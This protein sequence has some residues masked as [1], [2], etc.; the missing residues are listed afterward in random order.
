[1]ITVGGLSAPQAELKQYATQ[2]L[3]GPGIWAYPAYDSYEGS[4]TRA[5]RE[6]DL[7]AISLLNAGQEPLQSFYTLKRLLDPINEGLADPRLKGSFAEAG[8][9]TID[10]IADL[11]GILDDFAPTPEVRLTKLQKVLH[12]LKPELI[13]L[14]D[15]NI[16][17]LYLQLGT[18]PVRQ[19]KGRSYRDFALAWLPAVQDDLCRHMDFWQEITGLAD[20]KLPITP[21]RALDICAWKMGEKRS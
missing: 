19:V 13:P 18:R 16:W 10:A 9:D 6:A 8:Q 5:V 17:R 11:A 4:G 21:L 2:Y 3:Q 1:M 15:Q 14:Y 20:P 7:M 12:R